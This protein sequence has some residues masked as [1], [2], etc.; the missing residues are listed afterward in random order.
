M[1]DPTDVQNLDHQIM[2]VHH[3]AETFGYQEQPLFVEK[4]NGGMKMDR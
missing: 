3:I 4:S 1:F 2:T